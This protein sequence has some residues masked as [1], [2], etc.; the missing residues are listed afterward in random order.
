MHDNLGKYCY[1]VSCVSDIDEC[2][3]NPC[4]NGGSCVDD[5]NRFFCNCSAGYNDSVCS[6]GRS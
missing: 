3:S 4:E 1:V 5:V 2:V 6:T